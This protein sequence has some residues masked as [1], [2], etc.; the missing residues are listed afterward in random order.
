MKIANGVIT[1]TDRQSRVATIKLADI[2]TGNG[3]IHITDNVMMPP[4]PMPGKSIVAV[5]QKTPDLSSLLSALNFASNDGDLVKLLSKRGTFTM[6]APTNDAFN[7]LAAE[8]LGSGKTATDLLMP[9]NKALVR[10][11]L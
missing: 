7:G 6:F 11:V 3:L 8:P 4:R 5:A 1:I 2:F 10:T 9:A